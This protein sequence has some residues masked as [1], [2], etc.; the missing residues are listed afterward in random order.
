V[1]REF[2]ATV[3]HLPE[4]RKTLAGKLKQL[5]FNVKTFS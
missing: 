4:G 2:P 5:G 3:F 1:R